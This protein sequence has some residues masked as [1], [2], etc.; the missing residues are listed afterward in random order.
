LTDFNCF[1]NTVEEGNFALK[2]KVTVST[3]S[4]LLFVDY[5]LWIN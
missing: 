4:L 5:F 1:K 2:F 3:S